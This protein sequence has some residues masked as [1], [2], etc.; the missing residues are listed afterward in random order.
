MPRH[1]LLIIIAM[2]FLG[3][4][5]GYSASAL[6]P[7]LLV[8]PSSSLGP[9]LPPGSSSTSKGYSL[10]YIVE[11]Y[12]NNILEMSADYVN[13]TVGVVDLVNTGSVSVLYN[14]GYGLGAEGYTAGGSGS[15]S[16]A[17]VV[18]P[19]PDT[20]TTTVTETQ[21]TTATTTAYTTITTTITKEGRVQT[22]TY[23][24]P[25]GPTTVTVPQEKGNTWLLLAGA[26]AFLLLLALGL[27]KR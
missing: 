9:V 16:T 4:A 17:V 15:G 13:N 20:I 21:T 1:Y 10:G 27:L 22:V 2:M 24:V 5:L 23:T 7:S 25:L 8:A 11:V 19:T 6:S 3:F 12:R 18:D 26:G 14:L